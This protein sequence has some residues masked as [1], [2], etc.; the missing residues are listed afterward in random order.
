M[1][2]QLANETQLIGKT[3]ARVADAMAAPSCDS[4]LVVFFNDNTYAVF[5]ANHGYDGETEIYIDSDA[6]SDYAQ[7]KLGIID[8]AEYNKRK[9]EKEAKDEAARCRREL[10]ELRRLM[11]K[12]NVRDITDA[13][14]HPDDVERTFQ[15]K[16]E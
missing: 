3:I 14:V 15:I 12:H 5:N 11:V 8:E 16:V 6:L 10:N 13:G 2:D 7:Q 4:V 1:M 9:A